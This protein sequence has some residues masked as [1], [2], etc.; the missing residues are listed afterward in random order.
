MSWFAR[1]LSQ[2]CHMN[3]LGIPNY[4]FIYLTGVYLL[5]KTCGY[6]PSDAPKQPQMFLFARNE[7][8]LHDPK[9]NLPP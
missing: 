2:S 6:I 3:L 4:E 9:A 1:E 5:I 7:W 8:K